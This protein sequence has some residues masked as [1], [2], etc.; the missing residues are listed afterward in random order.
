MFVDQVTADRALPG[1][2]E[3]GAGERREDAGSPPVR[4]GGVLPSR[5]THTHTGAVEGLLPFVAVAVK[6]VHCFCHWV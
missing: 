4:Q 5:H 2:A 3:A 1:G 6:P